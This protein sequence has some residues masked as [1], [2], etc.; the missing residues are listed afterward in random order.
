MARLGEL[1]RRVMDVL[2]GSMDAELTV[3]QVAEELPRYA[4]TTL[5]TVLDRL[6]RKHMVLRTKDGRAHRYRAV[7]SRESYTAELMHEALGAVV[8]RDAVLVRF[9]E[10]VSPSEAR[11]L[12]QALATARADS[13]AQQGS[14]PGVAG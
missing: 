13:G 7:A 12:R 11:V 1:E 14:R 2:W 4:Y 8:D 5:M 3:R 9:A 10:T 6:H